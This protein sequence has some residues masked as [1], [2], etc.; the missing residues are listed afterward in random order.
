MGW[1]RVDHRA[2]SKIYYWDGQTYCPCID[3]F[4]S[5]QAIILL[6]KNA[7]FKKKKMKIFTELKEEEECFKIK[8]PLVGWRLEPMAVSTHQSGV[9]TSP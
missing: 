5:F 9:T 6:V 7:R 4:Y 1:F 3:Y 8:Y 2:I